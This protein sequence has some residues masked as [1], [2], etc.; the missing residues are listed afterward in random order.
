MKVALLDDYQ[1]L[2]RSMAEWDRLSDAEITAFDHHLGGPDDVVAALEPFDVLVAMR[3]RTAFPADV[4]ERLPNL[5]L[6]VTTGPANAAIDMDA[7]AARGITVAGTGGVDGNAS[8]VEMAWA[9][10][11]AVVRHVPEEDAR[12]RAGG[13]QRT[14]GRDLAGRRLGIVGLGGIGKPVAAVGQAFGMDV[15]AWSRHL[16]PE[17]A[18]SVG[19][20]PVSKE[21]LFSTA[22]VV[23]I[24]MKLS[25]GSRGL[26]GRAELDLMTANAVLVNTSR[27]PIVDEDALLEAVTEGRIGGAGLDVYGVEPLPVDSPWRSAPNTVLT[28]HLGYVTGETYTAMYAD[29]VE[30]IE[31]WAAG[32]AVPRLI[33]AP[34]GEQKGS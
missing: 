12:V 31:E 2:A 18:R 30:D 32:R 9:L 34:P 25:E 21:E 1:R 4:L 29:A 10:I 15:V 3:E 6:L 28:P 16:D 23:T 7:A 17:D 33:V 11:L 14:L 8:T 26:V 19:V 20:E 27:G 24:H 13:W 22:D 5:R